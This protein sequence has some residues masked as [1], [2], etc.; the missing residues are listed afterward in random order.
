M[1]LRDSSGRHVGNDR[2]RRRLIGGQTGVGILPR[3]QERIEPNG[4]QAEHDRISREETAERGSVDTISGCTITG[5]G[6]RNV[7]FAHPRLFP[8]DEA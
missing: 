1:V 2:R 4:E 8:R 3:V 5:H 7:T 6:A